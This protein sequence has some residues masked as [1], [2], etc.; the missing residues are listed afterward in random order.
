MGGCA[1]EL[2]SGRVFRVN[3]AQVVAD[4]GSTQSH[5]L[6]THMQPQALN[7][8]A[9]TRGLWKTVG[10][11]LLPPMDEQDVSSVCVT[12][13]RSYGCAWSLSYVEG[14]LPLVAVMLSLTCFAA[15]VCVSV[16]RNVVDGCGVA[17]SMQLCAATSWRVWPCSAGGGLHVS[18]L[19]LIIVI[20][21][22]TTHQ[23]RR[24][25]LTPPNTA[26]GAPVGLSCAV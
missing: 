20:N 14:R 22:I 19:R 24:C 6:A 2:K 16:R 26:S 13:C 1:G 3:V 21:V 12:C 11:V 8:A 18:S 7:T 9:P 4:A 5:F 25:C 17:G 10:D 23:W 15:C